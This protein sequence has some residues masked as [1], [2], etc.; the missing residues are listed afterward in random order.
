[1]RVNLTEGACQGHGRCHA[2]SPAVFDLDD[3]GYLDRGANAEVAAGLEDAARR[4]VESCPE[5]ALTLV[6][7]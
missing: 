2:V 4:G 3:D 5:R 6:E 1:M 7:H